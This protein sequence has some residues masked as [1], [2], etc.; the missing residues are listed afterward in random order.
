[1]K[2]NRLIPIV[3][4]LTVLVSGCSSVSQ[5][6][7]ESV[8][9]DRDE[10]STELSKANADLDDLK[11]QLKNSEPSTEEK[12]SL[13]DANEWATYF[14]DEKAKCAV[15]DDYH[16]FVSVQTTYDSTFDSVSELVQKSKTAM[17]CSFF[18][19]AFNEVTILYKDKRGKYLLGFSFKPSQPGSDVD[20]FGTYDYAAQ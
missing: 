4:L 14:I 3:L 17:D 2:K 20:I 7:Y 10:L 8:I 1:M 16:L 6:E 5:A 15:S 12:S 19:N 9:E 18:N 11:S 13:D